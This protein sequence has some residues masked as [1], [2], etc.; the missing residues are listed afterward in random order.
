MPNASLYLTSIKQPPHLPKNRYSAP[1]IL[2]RIFYY[3]EPQS[4]MAH[5]QKIS[6]KFFSVADP[7]LG[8]S[9][10]FCRTLQIILALKVSSVEKN[11]YLS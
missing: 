8:K 4:G 9:T 11:K 3:S 10:S 1:S 6:Q 7:D 2:Y 5:C